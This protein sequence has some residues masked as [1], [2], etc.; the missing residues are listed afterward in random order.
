MPS[1]PH[2]TPNLR[3]VQPVPTLVPWQGLMVPEPLFTRFR[4]WVALASW[5]PGAEEYL[6]AENV[7]WPGVDEDDRDPVGL[8]P[9]L[10][11]RWARLRQDLRDTYAPGYDSQAV[12]RAI[13]ESPAFQLYDTTRVRLNH[14]KPAVKVERRK[15]ARKAYRAMTPEARRL[16]AYRRVCAGR[17]PKLVL[18]LQRF[19]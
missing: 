2:I 16:K 17:V 10:Q 15:A 5:L 11:N 13:H 12:R 3:L 8:F 19:K 14:Q 4:Q 6:P 1:N 18:I 9:L 7:R